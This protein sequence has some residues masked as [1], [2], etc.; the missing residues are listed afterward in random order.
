LAPAADTLGQRGGSDA[1]VTAGAAVV[2]DGKRRSAPV[3]R[4][5]AR[6]LAETAAAS[7]TLTTT[8]LCERP[9]PARTSRCQI[10]SRIEQRMSLPPA[11]LSGGACRPG[12]YRLWGRRMGAADR[13]LDATSAA[14]QAQRR[15]A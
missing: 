3:G 14:G 10:V 4:R 9:H 6:P 12:G 2:R 1:P 7:Q 5:R 13:R 8:D 15:L 11:A